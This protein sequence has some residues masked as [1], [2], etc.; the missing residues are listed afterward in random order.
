MKNLNLKHLIG[1]QLTT[2]SQI[3][4]TEDGQR[5]ILD[6]TFLLTT[7]TSKQYQLLRTQAGLFLYRIDNLRDLKCRD[8][9]PDEVTIE[10]QT[11]HEIANPNLIKT[12]YTYTDEHYL[13]GAR[14]VDAQGSFIVGFCFGWDEMELKTE[15]EFQSLLKN[16][17]GHTTEELTLT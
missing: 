16:Y 1:A 5:Y 8:F 7:A 3:T 2:L 10:L 9:K 6:D 4:V 11:V 13:F 14:Y 12:I 17:P 15:T